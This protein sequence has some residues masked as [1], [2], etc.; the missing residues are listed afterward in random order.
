MLSAFCVCDTHAQPNK[1]TDTMVVG[2]AGDVGGGGDDTE[3]IMNG[4]QTCVRTAGDERFNT[5]V[6]HDGWCF[7][8]PC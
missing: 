8:R 1:N 7:I 2:G 3:E 5:A 6:V 4:Y